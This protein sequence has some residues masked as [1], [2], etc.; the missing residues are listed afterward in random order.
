MVLSETEWA[1]NG[2]YNYLDVISWAGPRQMVEHVR[3]NP[4]GLEP[5]AL[6][7]RSSH[8]NGALDAIAVGTSIVLEK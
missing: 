6:S 1:S 2:S 7:S 3:C 8:S 5:M 4:S